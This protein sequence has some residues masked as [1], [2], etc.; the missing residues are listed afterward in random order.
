VVD[1]AEPLPRHT[2]L[3]SLAPLSFGTLAMWRA[4]HNLA[5]D[6]LS[7][8]GLYPGQELVLMQLND[9]DGQTQTELQRALRLDHSTVSRTIRRME[10]AGLL[11]RRP[12]ETDKRAMVVSLTDQGRALCPA[13]AQLWSTTETAMAEALTEPQ[14]TEFA[15]LTSLLEE[16][17]V[18]AR[19]SRATSKP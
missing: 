3:S 5:T 13:V 19:K 2:A 17:L 16:S 11:A 9:S 12:A 18:A 10:V 15:E 8:L 6:M 14:R 7:E 1:D 4:L